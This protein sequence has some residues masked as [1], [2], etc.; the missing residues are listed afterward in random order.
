MSE[1]PASLSSNAEEPIP[2]MTIR[3]PRTEYTHL[4]DPLHER[5]F[6]FTDANGTALRAIPKSK[7]APDSDR[8]ATALPHSFI[9]SMGDDPYVVHSMGNADSLFVGVVRRSGGYSVE[10]HSRIEGEIS[11]LTGLPLERAL[12]VHSDEG[13][14]VMQSKGYSVELHDPSV[15]DLSK[16]LRHRRS[17]IAGVLLENKLRLMQVAR[18]IQEAAD[19]IDIDHPDLVSADTLEGNFRVEDPRRTRRLLSILDIVDCKLREM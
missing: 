8:N 1:N 12:E 17:A 10:T 16:F 5:E 11:E 19:A 15:G 14:E 7:F 9:S 3:R 4:S 2:L 18:R 6:W 13:K